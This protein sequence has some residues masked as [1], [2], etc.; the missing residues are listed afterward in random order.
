M[1]KR[2]FKNI[3]W[4]PF[5]ALVFYL[6]ILLLWRIGVIFSPVEIVLWLESLYKQYGLVGLAIA[7]FLEGIVYLGLY[8]PGSFIIFLSIILSDGRFISLFSISL[9]VAFI[10][11]IASTIN[12]FLGRHIISKGTK[13]DLKK[14][15]IATKG[16]FL[17]ALYPNS[18]AFYFFHSGI[19]KENP[20]KILLVPLII[21]PY[22]LVL[23]YIFYS[24]REGLRSAAES[25]FI[26][27]TI[28]LIWLVIALIIDHYKKKRLLT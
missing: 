13:S 3:P 7:S 8:F 28:I 16:L 9:V 18:L 20:M 26:M 15:K 22:L 24:F 23:S 17:S 14:E 6:T 10:L 27:I 11:T 4:L 12:Y 2:W 25:P 5:S 19:E 21:T 1:V